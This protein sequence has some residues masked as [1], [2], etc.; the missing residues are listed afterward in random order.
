MKFYPSTSLNRFIQDESIH[1]DT[2]ESIE[3]KSKSIHGVVDESIQYETE[4]ILHG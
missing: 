4:S 2:N 3:N 1:C